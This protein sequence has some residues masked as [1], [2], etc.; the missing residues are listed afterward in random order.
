MFSIQQLIERVSAVDNIAYYLITLFAIQAGLALALS[1]WRRQRRE[2]LVRRFLVGSLL[3]LV[4]RLILFVFVLIALNQGDEQLNR[5]LLPLEAALNTATV[6]LIT[7][8]L[9]PP[10]ERLPRLTHMLLVLSLAVTGLLYYLFQNQWALQPPETL[11]AETNLARIWTIIQLVILLLGLATL[12]FTGRSYSE[13]PTHATIIGTLIVAHTAHLIGAA[14]PLLGANQ[15]PFWLR[16]GYLVALP[17]LAVAIYRYNLS[18]LAVAT[19]HNRPLNQQIAETLNHS[20]KLLEH[21]DMSRRLP[22]ALALVENLIPAEWTAIGVLSTINPGHLHVVSRQ[23]VGEELRRQAWELNLADWPSLRLALK[24]RDRVEL[25]HNGLGARQLRDLYAELNVGDLGPLLI[26]PL[27][28]DNEEVGVLLLGAPAKQEKWPVRQTNLLTALSPFLARVIEN[29]RDYERQLR[30][31]STITPGLDEHTIAGRLMI[32]E[33]ER[34]QARNQLETLRLQLQ[35]AEARALAEEAHAVELARSIEQMEAAREQAREARRPEPPIH[36]PR[37][38]AL[39][40]EIAALRESLLQA[41]EALALAAARDRGLS[42]EWVVQAIT[43]YSAEL[44]TTQ[45][46]LQALRFRLSEQDRISLDESLVLLLDDLRTPLTSINGYTE[47]L[48]TESAGLLTR[49][50]KEYTER[51]GNNVNR[52]RAILQ[53][54]GDRARLSAAAPPEPAAAA[55]VNQVIEMATDTIINQLHSRALYLDLDL[56]ATLPPAPI[57]E[58]ALFRIVA[59]L[60]NNACHVSRPNSRVGLVAQ[61][62]AINETD[63]ANEVHLIRFLSIAVSDSSKGL[64]PD[65]L[66]L[67]FSPDH[68]GR[69]DF[70]EGIQDAHALTVA[71]GGRVWI[72][73][74]VGVGNSFIVL[75]PLKGEMPATA[76]VNGYDAG[77]FL[78]ERERVA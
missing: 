60:L 77:R 57:P 76:L 1:Q 23:L 11:F 41:E 40:S 43:R 50:Q 31:R 24:Q 32:M 47:L 5:Q 69:F 13:W 62:G 48:L 58:E 55:N 8:M 74:Q 12:P 7:W 59:H 34:D 39:E 61:A 4:T 64:T 3:L 66:P 73:S 2:P 75:L 30:E 19:H 14:N 45:A 35:R 42:A 22:E 27:H 10:P 38:E 20:Q 68:K 53:Q 16:L 46:E 49:S 65:E 72:E 54:I 51:I 17:L 56:P 70:V 29:A 36:A 63:G 28:A 44:E 21:P 71:N 25:V 15:A 33:K 6:L 18:W 26:E 9:V 78:L 37:I 52:M 67:V